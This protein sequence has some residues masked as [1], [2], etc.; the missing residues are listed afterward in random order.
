MMMHAQ[1]QLVS[2]TALPQM[3]DPAIREQEARRGRERETFAVRHPLSWPAAGDSGLVE[4]DTGLPDCQLRNI[5][6]RQIT[7]EIRWGETGRPVS[8][9]TIAAKRRAKSQGPS[10]PS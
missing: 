2:P 3:K 1:R 4:I 8:D 6:R 7:V 10:G 5:A 9:H